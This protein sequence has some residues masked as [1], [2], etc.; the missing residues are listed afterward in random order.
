MARV[1]RNWRVPG[2]SEV[3]IN[4]VKSFLLFIIII[5]SGKL[6]SEH[7]STVERQ[8]HQSRMNKYE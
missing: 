2:R 6:V 3:M 1:G 8:E 4:D 7:I 5:K